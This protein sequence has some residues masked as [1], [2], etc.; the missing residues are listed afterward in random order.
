MTMP[1][2]PLSREQM[3]ARLLPLLQE[4]AQALRPL[5]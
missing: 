2:Q 5:L 1:I 4:T 3:V